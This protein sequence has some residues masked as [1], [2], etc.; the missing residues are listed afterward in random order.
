MLISFKQIKLKQFHYYS[1]KKAN[2]ML[3]YKRTLVY[4]VVELSLS[5]RN[6]KNNDMEY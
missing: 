3:N 4:F 1:D 6:Y 5:L 2:K